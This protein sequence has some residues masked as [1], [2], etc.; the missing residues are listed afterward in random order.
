M[1]VAII[2]TSS[3]ARNMGVGTS[4]LLDMTSFKYLVGFVSVGAVKFIFLSTYT[5]TVVNIS[6]LVIV[7]NLTNS[8]R[9][10][11]EQLL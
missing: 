3:P 1:N 2:K 6:S 8:S 7:I 10:V 11:R 4:V 9:W 5:N